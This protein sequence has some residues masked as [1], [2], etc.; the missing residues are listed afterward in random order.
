MKKNL[1]E[2]IVTISHEK[3][4]ELINKNKKLQSMAKNDKL[5]KILL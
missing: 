5:V 2:I 4:I 1:F 3:F